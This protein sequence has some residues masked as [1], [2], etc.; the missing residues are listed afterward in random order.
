MI[1]TTRMGQ[2]SSRIAL[3]GAGPSGLAL[4]RAF[5]LMNNG[6][7]IPMIYCFEKQSDWGGKWNYTWQTGLDE[8]GE[9]V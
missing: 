3:I 2:G 5:E 7:N 9:P 1:S 6:G 8:H 4:L